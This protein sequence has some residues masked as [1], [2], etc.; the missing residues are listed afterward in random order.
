MRR[1]TIVVALSV[2]ALGGAPL[3]QRADP[4]KMALD[5]LGAGGIRTLQ[6][7]G[8]GASFSVARNSRPAEPWPRVTLKSY[9]AM[10]NYDT[11]SM[12]VEQL[13]EMG[14]TMPRGGGA[15]FTGEQRQTQTVSG[16]FAW[17]SPAP[18]ALP[19][20]GRGAGAPPPGAG[21]PP[22]GGPPGGAAGGRRGRGAAPGA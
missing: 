17:N 11:A 6:F 14:A 10:I 20:G 4:L 19:A 5:A 15:P 7:A 8:T 2:V 18:P 3:A 12:R 16:T 13:R 22:A 1:F 21:G 9:V